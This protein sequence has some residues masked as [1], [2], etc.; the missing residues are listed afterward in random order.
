MEK[1]IMRYLKKFENNN[2][3]LFDRCVKDSWTP[4]TIEMLKKFCDMSDDYDY[5]SEATDIY[6]SYISISGISFKLFKP[7]YF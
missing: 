2:N 7:T 4:F 1:Y 5:E 6:G 3:D